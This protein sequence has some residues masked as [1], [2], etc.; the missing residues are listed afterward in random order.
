V[1]ILVHCISKRLIQFFEFVYEC[2][3]GDGAFVSWVL[4]DVNVQ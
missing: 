4:R 1:G 2:S 3:G